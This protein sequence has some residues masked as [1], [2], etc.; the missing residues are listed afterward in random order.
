MLGEAETYVC[1]LSGAEE[2]VQNVT[3]GIL[4]SEQMLNM[5][6]ETSQREPR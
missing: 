2:A 3:V 1:L 5:C 4:P 6:S